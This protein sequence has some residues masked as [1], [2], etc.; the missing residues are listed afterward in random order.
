MNE[1]TYHNEYVTE[2][3]TLFIERLN[4]QIAENHRQVAVDNARKRRL[5]QQSPALGAVGK[6]MGGPWALEPETDTEYAAHINRLQQHL[7]DDPITRRYSNYLNSPNGR[8]PNVEWWHAVGHQQLAT[9]SVGNATDIQRMTLAESQQHGRDGTIPLVWDP[10]LFQHGGGPL[11]ASYTEWSAEWMGRMQRAQTYLWRQDTLEAACYAPLPEHI[12]QPNMLPFPDL[13]FSF[14]MAAWVGEDDRLLREEK[15][16]NLISAQIETWW[17]QVS[18]MGDAGAALLVSRQAWPRRQSGA[19]ATVGVEYLLFEP[20]PWGAKWPDDFKGRMNFEEIG[21]V[22]RMLA[23]MQAPFVDATQSRRQLPR[24]MRR[25]YEREKRPVPD[26]Q[27]SIIVL[28]RALH[29][30]TYPTTDAEGSTREY[31]HSWWVSGHYRWQYYPSEKTHRLVAIAPYI[32][33]A[34]KPLL[35]QLWDVKQ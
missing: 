32:K 15:S 29:E 3:L 6:L 10:R 30:P 18:R 1:P 7:M 4:R 14:E 26:K 2:Q 17:L 12:I 22:L 25:E 19:L 13:F 23:F 16:G 35:R 27:C 5:H 11:E 8:H 33:Q 31:K 24:P 21:Y 9:V 20:L 28:R 34:G